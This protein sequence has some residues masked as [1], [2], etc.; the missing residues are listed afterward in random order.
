[1]NDQEKQLV[2]SGER[3]GWKQIQ[4]LAAESDDILKRKVFG[5]RDNNVRAASVS[6]LEWT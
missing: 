4:G 1:M 3:V 2:Y 6:K 5:P